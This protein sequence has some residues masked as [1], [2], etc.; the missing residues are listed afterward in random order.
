MKF[1]F[2]LFHKWRILEHWPDKFGLPNIPKLRKCE[3]CGKR[4]IFVTGYNQW[5]NH[6][7]QDWEEEDGNADA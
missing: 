1:C 4:Q 7:K 3:R 2:F 5:V 6:P